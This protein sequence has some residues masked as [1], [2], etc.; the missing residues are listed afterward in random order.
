[1]QPHKEV[2]N[3]E[4][5][6][7]VLAGVGLAAFFAPP[8]RACR[9]RAEPRVDQRVRRRLQHLYRQRGVDDRQDGNVCY[10]TGPGTLHPQSPAAGS[11]RSLS[12]CRGGDQGSA[13]AN[14]N[15]QAC[16]P[17]GTSVA[18]NSVDRRGQS[19]GTFPPGCY[20]SSGA[21]SIVAGT[22]VTLSGD[23]VYIFRPGGALTTGPIQ[24]RP[25]RRRLRRQRLLGARGAATLGA[26][27]TF[28]GDHP[29]AAGITIGLRHLAGRALAFGGTV[30]TRCG[31]DHR[32]FLVRRA[33][34]SHPA[35]DRQEL[36]PDRHR[37][38]R[39][40]RRSPSP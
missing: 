27:S 13:L 35:H 5:C 29:D 14:L 8:P 22:T 36:Q 39:R 33:A 1:M 12:Q 17:L 26:N 34:G 21:M 32:P 24:S 30:T 6:L 4:Q 20:S 25:G 11:G 18:L 15:S 28:V 31:H 7:N 16:T 2:R 38:G 10:T 19:A 9:D 23:G 3:E 40:S 37:L